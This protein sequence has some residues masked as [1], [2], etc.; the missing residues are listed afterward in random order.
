MKPLKEFRGDIARSL[1]T[2]G[3]PKPGRSSLESYPAINRI[4]YPVVPRPLDITRRDTV[5]H[6]P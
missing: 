1:A 2:T 5:S 3:K 4:K 6:W